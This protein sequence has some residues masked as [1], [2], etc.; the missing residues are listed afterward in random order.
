MAAMLGGILGLSLLAV[1]CGGENPNLPALVPVSGTVTL[2]GKPLGGAMLSFAP[3]GDTRGNG[4]EGYTE[5]DGTFKLSSPPRGEGAA[6]GQYQVIIRKLVMPDGS[7]FPRNSDV[8]P[9]DSEA[10]ET[11][12]PKYSDAEQT[13]L[14][15]NVP[16]GGGIINF[17]LKSRP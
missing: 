7:D 4:A 5:P 17:D 14:T 8:A 13:T 16:E 9:M 1:G 2:D 6:V 3:V 11:L 10:K 15:A 12:S